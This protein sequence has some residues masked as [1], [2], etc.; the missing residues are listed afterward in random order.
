MKKNVKGRGRGGGGG[1]RPGQR[2]IVREGFERFAD[3]LYQPALPFE[4]HTSD[5]AT[6]ACIRELGVDD[7]TDDWNLS[8]FAN[9]PRAW[10]D[11]ANQALNA[12]LRLS[13]D[14]PRGLSCNLTALLVGRLGTDGTIGTDVCAAYDCIRKR[15]VF[16]HRNED[17]L[18]DATT[19]DLAE[20]A[21]A[22]KGKKR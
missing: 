15:L 20:S 21:A 1:V 8:R 5:S 6:P 17:V 22:V 9:P 13:F 16:W 4:I 11:I 19:D 10:I 18:R 2:N 12:G 14:V 3:H 7:P